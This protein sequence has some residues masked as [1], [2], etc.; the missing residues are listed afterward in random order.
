MPCTDNVHQASACNNTPPLPLLRP[1]GD[2]AAV[3]SS[4]KKKKSLPRCSLASWSPLSVTSPT[5]LDS[6]RSRRS[7]RTYPLRP[8]ILSRLL[9]LPR[10]GRFFGGEEPSEPVGSIVSFPLWSI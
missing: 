10:R 4:V 3:I 6:R 9:P 5:S 1:S 7:F 2:I 8:S